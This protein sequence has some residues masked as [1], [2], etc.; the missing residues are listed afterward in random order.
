MYLCICIYGY[1]YLYTYIGATH[2]RAGVYNST[3]ADECAGLRASVYVCMLTFMYIYIYISTHTGDQACIIAQGLMNAQ[4]FALLSV[5]QC[6]A[7][8]YSLSRE[9]YV[10]CVCCSVVQCVTV[11]RSV[12]QFWQCVVRGIRDICV[13]VCC[14]AWQCVREMHDM[15][16][17]SEFNSTRAAECAGLLAS[18]L[19]C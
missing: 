17:C 11:C 3:K 13:E 6:G 8:C 12:S 18:R 7:I 14:S 10:T 9:D 1:I 19:C 4:V 16:C 5:L 2:R 15:V